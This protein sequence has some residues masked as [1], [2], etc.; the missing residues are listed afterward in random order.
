M[1]AEQRKTK[2]SG[3]ALIYMIVFIA[4]FTIIMLPVI[5]NFAAKINLLRLTVVREQAFQIA[6]AG[7]N[8]YQWHLIKFIGDYKDGTGGLGPYVHDYVDFDTQKSIGH[9][10]LVIIPPLLGSTVV[11][12]KSTG[13]TNDNPGIKRTVTAIYGI[14]SLAQYSLLA[15]DGIAVYYTDEAF[16]GK[17]QSNNGIRFDAIGNSSIQSAKATYTCMS[18]QGDGCPTTKN[19]V[20]GSASPDVQALWQFPVPAIDFSSL[21]SDLAGMKSAAQSGGIY[22]PPSNKQGYS[23]VFN[24]NGTVSVYVVKKTYSDPNADDGYYVSRSEDTDY[25]QRISPSLPIQSTYAIPANG[26]IYVEDNV[27]VEGTVNGRVTVAAAI[28]PQPAHPPIIFIPQNIVYKEKDGSDVLGLLAQGDIVLSKRAPADLEIDAAM[29]SQAGLIQVFNTGD[30]KNNLTI[31]GS[32]MN[33]G[34]WFDNFVWTNGYT[35]IVISGY[36]STTDNYDT[37]LLYAPPPYF[38]FSA[39][40]YQ[41]LKWASD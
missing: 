25:D 19:G 40:G 37:N 4:V 12:I 23:L 28:L 38:P 5:D 17:I 34:Y 6:E 3:A 39:S 33:F 18:W 22:L 32:V 27:W 35:N 7:T 9:F 13:W 36:G 1:A 24:N 20:W 11:T 10:S 26:I 14:P 2:Q 31:Y 30:V 15:N 16:N 8:Y 21:T 41:L 29:I